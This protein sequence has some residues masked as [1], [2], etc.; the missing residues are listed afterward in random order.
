MSEAEKYAAKHKGWHTKR[1]EFYATTDL[2]L[3]EIESLSYFS[4]NLIYGEIIPLFNEV[5]PSCLCVCVSF[6]LSVRLSV[7]VIRYMCVCLIL[8]CAV[9]SSIRM[10]LSLTGMLSTMHKSASNYLSIVNVEV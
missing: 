8:S 1:H 6:C 2:L 3:T 7:S 5:M 10:V 9:V 4:L